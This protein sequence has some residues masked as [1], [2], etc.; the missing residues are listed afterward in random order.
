MGP[1]PL[2]CRVH[3][4]LHQRT[5]R[6]SNGG[7]YH[8][9][10][11]LRRPLAHGQ[12]PPAELGRMQLALE[13]LLCVGVLGHHQQAGG[14]SVQPVDRV[15]I[16]QNPLGFVIIGDKIPQRIGIM[17]RSRVAGHA[18]GLVDDQQILVLVHNIQRAGDRD[19][20]AAQAPIGHPDGEDLS[21]RRPSVGMHPHSVQ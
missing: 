9:G 3:P 10:G 11:G 4:A 2:P 6:R 20:A 14:P 5:G 16:R 1:G 12:V 13:P 19:H 21:F 18:G 15:E 17:A 7:V 8:T